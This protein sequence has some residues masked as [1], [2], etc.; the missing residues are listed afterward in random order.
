MKKK[1]STV[2]SLLLIL[3]LITIFPTYAT[4]E[5]MYEDLLV[6]RLDIAE[7]SGNNVYYIYEELF[8]YCSDSVSNTPDYVLVKAASPYI[9]EAFFST[10]FGEY[11]VYTCY[12]APYTHAYHIYTPDD[13]KVY[14][15]EEA[16]YAE[17]EGLEEALKFLNG[18]AVALIG[19]ADADFSLNIKD[20]TWIQKYLADFVELYEPCGH[21]QLTGE[22]CDFNRDGK[23]NIRDAT[24]LQ[25]YLAKIDS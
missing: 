2:M 12:Y 19:D 10:D 9:G 18:T 1:T 25:K 16:Y 13:D 8:Y 20:A 23:I 3:C 6:E 4:K 11:V 5:N 15:L 17:I 22:A 24:A 14:T 21:S 7:I